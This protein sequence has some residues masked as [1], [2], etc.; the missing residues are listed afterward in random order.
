M[1]FL[2]FVIELHGRFGLEIPEADYQKLG[3][4]ASIVDYVSAGLGAAGR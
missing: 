3:S 2:R 4:L 1:D